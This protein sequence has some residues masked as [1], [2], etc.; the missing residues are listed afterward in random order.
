[1]STL[2][3]MLHSAANLPSAD[4]T[5][6]SDPFIFF[7]INENTSDKQRSSIVYQTLDPV[8]DDEIFRFALPEGYAKLKMSVFDFDRLSSDDFLG[9]AGFQISELFP[10]DGTPVKMT[11]PLDNCTTPGTVTLTLTY[12]SRLRHRAIDDERDVEFLVDAFANA[13]EDEMLEFVQ[14][15]PVLPSA[16]CRPAG[17][18][19][20]DTL[21]AACLKCESFDP[22]ERFVKAVADHE[23]ERCAMET[24]FLRAN[25]LGIFTLSL[26]PIYLAPKFFRM[27]KWMVFSIHKAIEVDFLRSKKTDI[28]RRSMDEGLAVFMGMVC[29]SSHL[30]DPKLR[31]LLFRLRLSFAAKFPDANL[32]IPSISTLF[33]RCISP[34]LLSPLSYRLCDYV[35]K[36]EVQMVVIELTR[37]LQSFINGTDNISPMVD[38]FRPQINSLFEFVNRPVADELLLL[39]DLPVPNATSMRHM[40]HVIKHHVEEP[41]SGIALLFLN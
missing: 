9:D 25:T 5:G 39:N 38:S 7:K 14:D 21:V 15:L 8:W 32:D 6:F 30:L 4:I 22:L 16:I 31:R 24:E 13:T 20:L 27:L 3:I 12:T 26:L 34:A 18:G 35:P 23:A 28:G 33:L 37:E 11:L 29:S 36:K 40:F 19:L 41:K 1:M 17:K 10:L 2:E